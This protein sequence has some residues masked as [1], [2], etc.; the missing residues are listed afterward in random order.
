MRSDE[1]TLGRGL[2]DREARD[3]FT[4]HRYWPTRDPTSGHDA[5]NRTDIGSG[6]FVLVATTST[7]RGARASTLV[8]LG[9][10]PGEST[11]VMSLCGGTRRRT[12]ASD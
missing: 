3:G 10:S 11:V 6:A 9:V 1:D 5:T 2:E 12:A 4:D 7:R 8:I